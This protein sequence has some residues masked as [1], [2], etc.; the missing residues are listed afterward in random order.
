MND[1]FSLATIELK[2]ASNRLSNIMYYSTRLKIA[3]GTA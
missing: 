1:E 2:G 3:R